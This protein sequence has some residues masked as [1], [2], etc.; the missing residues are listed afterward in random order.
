MLESRFCQTPDGAIWC[1]GTYAYPFWER[2]LAVFD[3]VNVIARVHPIAMYPEGNR[4]VDGPKVRV[5]PMPY[6]VGPMQYMLKIWQLHYAV[7]EALGHED[8]V[9]IRP[10]CVASCLMP[11]LKAYQRPYG[12]EV[13]GDPYDVY[14]PTS[15]KHPLRPLFRRSFPRRL[16]H[17]CQGAAAIC[18]VNG[19]T[20]PY[21]YPPR[22]ENV[23]TIV[24]SD[25]ELPS[26]AFR[27]TPRICLQRDTSVNIVSVGSMAQLYKGF[28][29]LISAL[30]LCAKRGLRF[31]LTIVGDG[32]YRRQIEAYAISSGIIEH[33]KFLGQLPSGE[34]VQE[35]LD[36]AD[37]FVLASRTEGMPRA[38]IEAMARGLPCIGTDVGGI[39]ELLAAED[40][41]PTGDAQALAC[42]IS[43]SLSDQG[44][45]ARASNRNL[46]T[47][48]NYENEVLQ[49][50]RIAFLESIANQT[51]EWLAKRFA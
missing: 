23:F 26:T 30:A 4:R 39:P 37:L 21:R 20:L 6:Y 9:I 24:C 19:L 31:S 40:I 12:I 42:K 44:W 51:K 47:A 1:N 25:V 33:T 13:V 32:R 10:G 7:K 2:Y 48:R 18:Y 38:L 46:T 34:A 49:T 28:D 11:V 43:A 29:I 27:D 50:R 45:M 22:D 14:A 8:A 17:M 3:S 35:Q 16:R 41:V 5:S 36:N 15:V